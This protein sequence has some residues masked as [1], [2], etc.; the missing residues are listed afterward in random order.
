MSAFLGQIHYWLFDKIKLIIEREELILQ[1]GEAKLGDL[2]TEMHDVALDMYGKPIPKD[3]NLRMII[4]HDNIHGWLQNQIEVASVR[5]ASFIKDLLDV[6]GEEAIDAVLE[7]F[8]KQGVMCGKL[9]KD[10]LVEQTA[11]AIYKIMQDFYVNGMPCDAPDTVVEDSEDVF[12]WQGDHHNQISAWQK[13]GVN[14]VFM[15]AAYQAWF[16]S[17][18]NTVAP[19]FVFHVNLDN[20]L[21]IY[22][23][24]KK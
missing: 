6:G 15:A 10:K 22:S 5:E 18:V 4:D 17:F 23:I 13:A 8:I 12:A 2:A 16:S 11:P 1:E 7:A 3:R 9:A 24:R 19:D 20:Q 14:P 21:P